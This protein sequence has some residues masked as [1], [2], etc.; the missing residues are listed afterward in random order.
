MIAKSKELMCSLLHTLSFISS[1]SKYKRL[2]ITD[3]LCYCQVHCRG[4]CIKGRI[5][6]K[7]TFKDLFNSPPPR[8]LSVLV[9][10]LIHLNAHLSDTVLFCGL[11]SCYCLSLSLSLFDCSFFFLDQVAGG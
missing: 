4:L 3:L 8:Q 2:P 11:L 10:I 1:S 6:V 9:T 5:L 7:L